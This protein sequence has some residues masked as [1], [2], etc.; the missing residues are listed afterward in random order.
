MTSRR[1]KVPPGTSEWPTMVLKNKEAVHLLCLSAIGLQYM[2][3]SYLYANKEDTGTAMHQL[4]AM[5]KTAQQSLSASEMYETIER[6]T[7]AL[8]K[9]GGVTAQEMLRRLENVD[10]EQLG[11]LKRQGHFKAVMDRIKALAPDGG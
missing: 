10:P 4:E 9:N 2:L 5:L 3:V 8:V 11:L 7:Q 1:P 6:V